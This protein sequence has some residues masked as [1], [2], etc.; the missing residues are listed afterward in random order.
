MAEIPGNSAVCAVIGS[1]GVSPRGIARNG[2]VNESVASRVRGVVG[3]MIRRGA[4]VG[5]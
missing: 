2:R 5:L 3:E 1:P 4:L